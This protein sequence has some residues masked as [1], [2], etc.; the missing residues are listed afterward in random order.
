MYKIYIYINIYICITTLM[1]YTIFVKSLENSFIINALYKALS[2]S[3]IF[4]F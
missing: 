1:F 2:N 4:K 3:S